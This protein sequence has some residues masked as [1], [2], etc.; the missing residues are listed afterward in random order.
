[1][2]TMMQSFMRDYR[3]WSRSEQRAARAILTMFLL[4]AFILCGHLV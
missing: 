1:M 3:R 2:T 4:S